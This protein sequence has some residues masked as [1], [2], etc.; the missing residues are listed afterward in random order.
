MLWS[1]RITTSQT[2]CWHLLCKLIQPLSVKPHDTH[3]SHVL[4]YDTKC[5]LQSFVKFDLHNVHCDIKWWHYVVTL[6]NSLF[7]RK[8]NV[9]QIIFTNAKWNMISPVKFHTSTP[10]PE[11]GILWHEM[12]FAAEW[13]VGSIVTPQWSVDQWLCYLCPRNTDIKWLIKLG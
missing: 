4:W 12:V 1:T 5:V 9:P 13:P 7:Y 6:F 8:W 2:C 10:Y 3:S 11:N